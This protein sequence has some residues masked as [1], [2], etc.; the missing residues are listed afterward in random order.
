MFLK[1]KG[2]SYS[3]YRKIIHFSASGNRSIN[4]ILR[5]LSI[6]YMVKKS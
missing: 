4:E 3:E 2:G 1:T 5:N 6:N